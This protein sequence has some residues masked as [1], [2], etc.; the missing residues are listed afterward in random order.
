MLVK[1]MPSVS[2]AAVQQLAVSGQHCVWTRE[3]I[4]YIAVLDQKHTQMQVALLCSVA[5]WGPE[6]ELWCLALHLAQA[7]RASDAAVLLLA[8]G[9]WPKVQELQLGRGSISAACLPQLHH[10]FALRSCSLQS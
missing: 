3:H 1:L 7:R 6:G 2:L 8:K 10:A 9:H 5:C 4:R